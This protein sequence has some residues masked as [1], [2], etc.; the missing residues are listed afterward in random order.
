VIEPGGY[1]RD[2]TFRSSY[3]PSRNVIQVGAPR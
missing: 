1:V 2:I 3:Q